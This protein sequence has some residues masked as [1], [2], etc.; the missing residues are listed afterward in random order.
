MILLAG[1]TPVVII[2]TVYLKVIISIT[3]YFLTAY[4]PHIVV[5]SLLYYVTNT[6]SNARFKSC[7]LVFDDTEAVLYLF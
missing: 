1:V 6:N 3:Y 4:F 2:L 7:K 5:E